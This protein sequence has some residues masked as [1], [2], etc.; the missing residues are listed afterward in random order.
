MITAPNDTTNKAHQRSHEKAEKSHRCH[1]SEETE[2]T[3]QAKIDRK[4]ARHIDIDDRATGRFALTSSCRHNC[5]EQKSAAGGCS[6]Q[7]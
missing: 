6:N 4:P 3:R 7:L 2:E 1:T 5:D